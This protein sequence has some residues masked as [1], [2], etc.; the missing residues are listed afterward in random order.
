[1]PRKRNE[2]NRKNWKMKW[3]NNRSFKR[4]GRNKNKRNIKKEGK[5]INEWSFDLHTTHF[6]IANGM[7]VVV[8]VVVAAIVTYISVTEQCKPQHLRFSSNDWCCRCYSVFFSYFRWFLF[9]LAIN[10]YRFMPLK[11]RKRK[12]QGKIVASGVV[13]ARQN[14]CKRLYKSL[15]KNFE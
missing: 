7:V 12:S 6:I 10:L 1:M 4:P 3:S 2:K 5:Q 8:V 13:I 14:H 9:I 11:K 15:L